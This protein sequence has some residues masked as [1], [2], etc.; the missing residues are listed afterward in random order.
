[1]TKKRD[2]FTLI[3]L[4]AG[5]GK[6]LED[7]T[8]TKPKPLVEVAG[9]PLIWHTI[10]AFTHKYAIKNI[11]IAAYYKASV[12]ID[13]CK[14]SFPDLN[15]EFSIQP[16]ISPGHSFMSLIQELNPQGPVIITF[17]DY[18]YYDLPE[19]NQSSVGLFTSNSPPCCVPGQFKSRCEVDR[20][21]RIT[22]FVENRE[23]KV[24]TG[25]CGLFIC[26]EVDVLKKH[27]EICIAKNR[28]DYTFD[29]VAGFSQIVALREIP[30]HNLFNCG[31]LPDL[32]AT[33]LCLGK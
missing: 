1:M 8:A 20:Y 27:L 3:I 18:I 4:A 12:L 6:R 9:K 7:E 15:I 26:Y 13:Y 19:C 30:I 17:C 16:A 33:R 2:F 28:L 11:T 14:K 32:T 29:I 25:F 22:N 21:G 23:N 10:N 24:D 5:Y 31:E